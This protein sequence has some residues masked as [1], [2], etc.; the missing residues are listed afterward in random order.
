[1]SED[2]R[3]VRELTP[4]MRSV[5]ADG[6]NGFTKRLVAPVALSAPCSRSATNSGA[7]PATSHELSSARHSVASQSTATAPSFSTATNATRRGSHA[8]PTSLISSMRTFNA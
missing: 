7:S 4:T 5:T 2:A 3:H 1:M 6:L 8:Q